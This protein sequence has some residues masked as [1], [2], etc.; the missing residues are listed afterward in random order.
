M[1]SRVLALLTLLPQGPFAPS[2]FFDT[3]LVTTTV[4]SDSR[5]ATLAFVDDL[6]ETRGPDLGC[7]D[8]SLVFRSAPCPRAALHTP[9]S[10][11]A[12][13]SPD[14]GAGNVVFAAT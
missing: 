8:G 7:A 11:P 2:A 10:F 5:C 3:D 13:A 4:P 14:W 6:Y 12:R 1:P 9:P